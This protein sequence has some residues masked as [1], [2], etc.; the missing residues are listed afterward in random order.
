[1]TQPPLSGQIHRLEEDLGVQLFIRVGHGVRLTSAGRS[2]LEEAR[3]IL[4]RAETAA[5]GQPIT[6]CP[7]CGE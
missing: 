7:G 6:H 4:A 2:F 5:K 1:M 3:A